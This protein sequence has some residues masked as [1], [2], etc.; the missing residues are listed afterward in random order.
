MKKED[1]QFIKETIKYG[2]N[3]G[4]FTNKVLCKYHDDACKAIALIDKELN[5]R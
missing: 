1:L 5:N 3:H 4:N 2:L